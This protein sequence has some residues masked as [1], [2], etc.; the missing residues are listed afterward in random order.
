ML[1]RNILVNLI[2]KVFLFISSLLTFFCS[3][4]PDVILRGVRGFTEGQAFAE[5]YDNFR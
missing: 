1:N 2:N 4:L 3:S 5:S